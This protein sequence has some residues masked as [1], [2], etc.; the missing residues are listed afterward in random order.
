I[1]S[2]FQLLWCVNGEPIG[3]VEIH[4]PPGH[5]QRR[6]GELEVKKELTQNHIIHDNAYA[7][8]DE[9]T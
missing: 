4:P 9:G 1:G 8:G 7:K 6:S 5:F 3:G 2:G